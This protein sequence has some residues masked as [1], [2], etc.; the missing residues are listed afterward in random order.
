MFLKICT[1]YKYLKPVFDL[2][3][4]KLIEMCL[5]WFIIKE[6]DLFAI[7]SCLFGI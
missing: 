4:P 1:N 5:R 2:F 3:Y 7:A 6:V